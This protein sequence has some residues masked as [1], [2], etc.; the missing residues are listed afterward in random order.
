MMDSESVDTLDDSPN[1]LS[2]GALW[3]P[4]GQDLRYSPAFLLP[5]ILGALESTLPPS[6][7][8]DDAYFRFQ[9]KNSAYQDKHLGTL[10][11]M[12]QKLCDRGVLS[13]CLASLA[14]RCEKIRC[15]AVGI[16]GILLR[17]C[18]SAE[19]KTLSS[20][21]GRP[22]VAMLL[23]SVQRAFVI[24]RVTSSSQGSPQ[25]IPILSPLISTFLARSSLSISKP[26]DTMFV[27][28]NR[29][30]LKN[31]RDH[32][33]FPDMN[34]LPAFISFFCSSSDDPTQSRKERIWA[35]QHVRDGFADSSCY[36]LVASCHA[37][38]LILTSFENQRLSRISIDMKDSE[39]TLMLNVFSKFINF[40]SNRV[41]S[42]LISRL[43]LLSWMRS[44]STSWPLHES[45]PGI[46]SR[47]AFCELVG[48]A[49]KQ[50]S[51]DKRLRTDVLLQEVCGLVQPVA[52]FGIDSNE[53][54]EGFS[55]LV[56][57][58]CQALDSLRMVLLRLKEDYHMGFDV[59]SLGISIE[60]SLNLLV[61]AKSHNLQEKA[62]LSLS[63]LPVCLDG[64]GLDRVSDFCTLLLV[65]CL[66]SRSDKTVELQSSII[67][68]VML[69][70]NRVGATLATSPE[71]I[72]SLL[73]I[74]SRFVVSEQQHELL[75][76]CLKAL[77]TDQ[78]CNT[79]S[80]GYVVARELLK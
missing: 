51:R 78:N 38:E 2:P 64:P 30:F 39:F 69:I 61:I 17:A 74:R 35:L 71:A 63:T 48:C 40:G 1:G 5:F 50:A 49:V 43:G 20:W 9:K 11:L 57:S 58:I 12:V 7:L 59:N 55:L 60:T 46:K 70:A 36:R 8:K 72:E 10:A 62:S 73:A 68:R 4:H 65:S 33:A 32:G 31:E 22:Q 56:D 67:E 80:R 54:E 34:R 45:F 14:S 3:N 41:V 47:I 79:E 25:V 6:G 52:L 29:Y 53:S 76:Q 75:N 19:A 44:W 16:L 27:P 13:L 28:L 42:H 24:K 18:S 23:N 66:Q 21:R 26:D 15:Y 77:A 37:P